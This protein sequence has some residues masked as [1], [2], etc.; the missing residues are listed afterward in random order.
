MNTTMN[1]TATAP[2]KKA[3][4]HRAGAK[5][6]A[7]EVSQLL[8]HGAARAAFVRTL[9]GR[10]LSSHTITAYGADVEQFTSWL[11]STDVSITRPD[12]VTRSTITNYLVHLAG[13]GNSGVTRARKLAALREFF[14]YLTEAG[15]ISAS[16]AA[17]I[18]M[19]QKERKQRVYLRPDEF[20]K[21]LA[22]AGGN[23][24][25]FAILQLFLQTGI[26][27]SELVNLRTGDVDLDGRTITITGKG[28]NQR[29]IVLEKKGTQA[30]ASYLKVR[31]DSFDDHLFL[32]YQGTGLS[33]T[34]VKKLVIKYRD[35]AGISKRISA[36]SL[37]H[38]FATYKASR[39]VSAFQLKEWLGHSSISTSAI[40]VHL[41][42]QDGRKPMEATSL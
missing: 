25:D 31:E 20:S 4:E 16:P 18:D 2:A 1:G 9:T 14:R 36:H 7:L 13:L 10:N 33:L 32:S 22:V 28:K 29:E 6:A 21:M 19:P 5:K 3:R 34:A 12:Q 39:G 8:D 11:E 17:A 27:I 26:R 23:P 24:R 42:K 41:A 35:L 15:V 37:R 30:L 40:Y 38:T